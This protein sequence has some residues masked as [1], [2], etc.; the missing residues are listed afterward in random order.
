MEPK[1]W[2]VVLSLVSLLA[3]DLLVVWCGVVIH[4]RSS[5]SSLVISSTLRKP[6]R[7]SVSAGLRVITRNQVEPSGPNYITVY[8]SYQLASIPVDTREL[9]GS[10]ESNHIESIDLIHLDCNSAEWS[11]P[12]ALQGCQAP[13]L[14]Y[15][16][17]IYVHP[18]PS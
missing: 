5:N 3:N 13:P 11:V 15:P 4:C 12:S 7:C 8:T 17:Y 18:S 6:C 9:P 2:L 10:T 1:L 14:T 16:A